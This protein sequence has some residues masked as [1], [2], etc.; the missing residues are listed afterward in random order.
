MA[1]RDLSLISKVDG[2]ICVSDASSS[3]MGSM[4]M[5]KN[6][7]VQIKTEDINMEKLQ[8]NDE[9][10]ETYYEI[11]ERHRKTLAEKNITISSSEDI[12][13][14]A[15]EN[16]KR[17]DERL[18]KMKK[19]RL[20][21]DVTDGNV[22][23]YEFHK[24]YIYRKE[25]VYE[26]FIKGS[27]LY[28]QSS[29]N[30]TMPVTPV[31][32][33]FEVHD[34]PKDPP[35]GVVVTDIYH[36][37]SMGAVY[38]FLELVQS[39]CLMNKDSANLEARFIAAQLHGFVNDK[40]YHGD[41]LCKATDITIRLSKFINAEELRQTSRI[42]LCNNEVILSINPEIADIPHPLSNGRSYLSDNEPIKGFKGTYQLTIDLVD[43][44]QSVKDKFLYISGNIVRIK[45][46]EDNMRANGLYIA[47]TLN[48]E[49]ISLE[50]SYFDLESLEEAHV[51]NTYEEAV[52]HGN[53]DLLLAKYKFQQ[54]KAEL[55][56]SSMSKEDRRRESDIKRE[57]EL[58]KLKYENELAE[59][60]N[61][62]EQ[63]K[64]K[65]D[66]YTNTTKA[67][68]STAAVCLAIFTLY[69]KFKS[70]KL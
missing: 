41:G 11:R 38:R 39:S 37:G 23:P 65:Y 16:F 52:T 34:S 8:Q 42:Y 3:V 56:H 55:E 47:H 27:V 67:I 5:P 43:N 33:V 28:V 17:I 59:R 24:S 25:T 7:K 30:I 53:P 4:M 36:F 29:D 19:L 69:T 68:A 50:D 51:Y 9:P 15:D 70:E 6:N 20:R 14:N 26:N 21:F 40:Q 44:D 35:D 49:R 22:K 66:T 18:K 57:L 46:F 63:L 31:T 64:S 2:S 32:N 48:G 45:P 12:L 58:L 13:K 62:T 60:K 54:S 10:L 1:I 61:Q